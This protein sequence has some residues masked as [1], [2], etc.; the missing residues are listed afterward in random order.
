[1]RRLL[2]EMNN[3]ETNTF[4]FGARSQLR[5]ALSQEIDLAIA[6]SASWPA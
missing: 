5:E 6:A 1:M 2:E 4:F 3:E